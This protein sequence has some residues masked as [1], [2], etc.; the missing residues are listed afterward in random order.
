MWGK[1]LVVGVRHF[2]IG[3]PVSSCT[4]DISI[5]TG[6]RYRS[7]YIVHIILPYSVVCI[8]TKTIIAV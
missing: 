1:L 8:H 6:R 7:M 5:F 2:W 4:N 3:A